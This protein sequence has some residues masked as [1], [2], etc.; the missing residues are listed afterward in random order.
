MNSDVDTESPMLV[1]DYFRFK[2]STTL[3]A[4]SWIYFLILIPFVG[5]S[6]IGFALYFYIFVLMAGVTG[7]LRSVLMFVRA[8]LSHRR[9]ISVLL[10]FFINE[11]IPTVF[12][13]LLLQTSFNYS[14]LFVNRE[15]YQLDY[16][17][18]VQME[19]N[20]RTFGCLTSNL[21]QQLSNDHDDFSHTLQLLSTMLPFF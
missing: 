6:L 14:L 8:Q 7:L 4:A 18:V 12:L 11:S 21:Q 1:S 15:L 20:A 10:D 17:S 5:F 3:H 9:F 13:A 19:Y 2:T 16:S